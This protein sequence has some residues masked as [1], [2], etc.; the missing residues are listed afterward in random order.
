[1]SAGNLSEDCIFLHESVIRGHH[2]V[3][4]GRSQPSDSLLSHVSLSHTFQPVVE[5]NVR[6]HR[7]P[8]LL[9]ACA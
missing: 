1:M 9:S 8:R 3:S 2:Q 7:T 4:A 5:V 6:V